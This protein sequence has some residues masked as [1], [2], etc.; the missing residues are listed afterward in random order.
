[1]E[2]DKSIKI[3]CILDLYEIAGDLQ[4]YLS[5][6]LDNKR[7]WKH[8]RYEELYDKIRVV[9][10][11]L[12]Q[13]IDYEDIEKHQNERSKE[14]IDFK[15]YSASLDRELKLSE[16][17]KELTMQLFKKGTV[18][19]PAM[20]FGAPCWQNEIYAGMIKNGIMRGTLHKD[21]KINVID[22]LKADTMIM[23]FIKKH[24]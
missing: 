2:N 24:F 22:V 6:F 17:L 20:P 10:G 5:I 19:N 16:Y 8:E 15:F 12:Q 1:M 13:G 7:I 18:F 21:G 23:D 11:E 3:Q 14:M 9:T 4:N